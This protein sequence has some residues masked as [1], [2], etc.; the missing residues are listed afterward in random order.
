M[1]TEKPDAGNAARR[2]S[3][4]QDLLTLIDQAPQVG[5]LPAGR[6]DMVTRPS[7]PHT[8]IIDRLFDGP[9]DLIYR[10][11]TDPE[12]VAL[13]WGVENATNPLCQLDVRPGGRWRIDMQTARGKRYRNE[14]VYIDV[15]ENERLVYTDIPN[16]SIPEWDGQPP[17]TRIHT[18]TFEDRGE[19]THVLIEVAFETSADR[20]RMVVFGMPEGLAQGLDRF[21]ALL[22]SIR[23]NPR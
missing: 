4:R 18:V 13:W 22:A 7:P 3:G 11:W 10:I 8:I 21:A 19:Q 20:D 9:I 14:G 12:M 1:P 15:V 17:G 5:P 23:H 16:P 6:T 2:Q